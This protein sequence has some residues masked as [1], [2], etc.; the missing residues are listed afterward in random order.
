MKLKKSTDNVTTMQWMFREC[1]LLK[2]L[3]LSKFNTN[4]V[5]NMSAMFR[6]CISIK[7][8]KRY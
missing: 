4:N 1:P 5:T 2:K 8:F 3:N 7:C 6:G